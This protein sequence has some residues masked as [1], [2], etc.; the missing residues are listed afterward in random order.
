M[1]SIGHALFLGVSA[2][3]V[4]ILVVMHG[5]SWWLATPIS[6]V[7]TTAAGTAILYPTYRLR[8]PFFSLATWVL[9]TVAAILAIYAVAYT[10]G[11][12]GLTWP[13]APS[14]STFTYP[15]RLP[16]LLLA[17]F[18]LAAAV[19]ASNLSDAGKIGYYL[20][21]MREDDAAAEAIGV[22]TTRVRLLASAVSIAVTS[23]C[24]AFYAPFIAFIDPTSAFSIT[25]SLQVVLLA[26]LGGL[27]TR[28]GPIVGAA[29]FVPIDSALAAQ[30][31][32]GI[33]LFL[34]GVLLMA[35]VVFLP[36]GVVGEAQA[37]LGRR[38]PLR[39]AARR[40]SATVKRRVHAGRHDG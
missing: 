4:A 3:C 40:V 20:R 36:R 34:L 29:I 39:A 13:Y 31:S 28:Y 1:V 22:P 9:P 5:V 12:Q 21:A 32:G 8:G 33:H 24:G 2:Y 17:G 30:F 14:A 11:P 18:V 25:Y 38:T 27:G 19:A 26:I 35:I 10:N 7:V 15:T 6:V 23:L 37:R 16:Y